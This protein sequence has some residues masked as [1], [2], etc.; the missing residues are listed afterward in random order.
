MN[1]RV[2]DD[3]LD[4]AAASPLVAELGAELLDR[5]GIPDADPDHLSAEHLAP[6]TGAFVLAWVHDAAVGCGGVRRYGDGVGELK[7]M[8]VQPAFRGR[9]I[10]RSVL[11]ALEARARA[12]GYGRLLLETGVRQPEAIGLYEAAGYVPIEPYG[13]YRSSPLS[14]CFAKPL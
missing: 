10:A 11:A 1:L 9:G 3:R 4:A 8:Y 5:Y 12:L 2:E 7:R 6:P 14:R 13:Y